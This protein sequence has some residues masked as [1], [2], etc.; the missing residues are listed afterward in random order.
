[1]IIHSKLS[2]CSRICVSGNSSCVTCSLLSECQKMPGEQDCERFRFLSSTNFCSRSQVTCREKRWIRTLIKS[3]SDCPLGR[4]Q[5][6]A[7]LPRVLVTLANER[8]QTNSHSDSS[9]GSRDGN[10]SR[11]R[12]RRTATWPI[13]RL[14]TKHEITTDETEAR[15][16]FVSGGSHTLPVSCFYFILF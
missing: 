7:D 4:W 16:F 3:Q 8:K 9:S 11:N 12:R 13:V 2:N 6:A 5:A 15:S 10:C 1:M 14:C